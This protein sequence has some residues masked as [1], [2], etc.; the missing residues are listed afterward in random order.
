M[1]LP[2]LNHLPFDPGKSC[3]RGDRQTLIGLFHLRA[4][5]KVREVPYLL[6]QYRA[7]LYSTKPLSTG[8]R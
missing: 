7:R 1:R 4:E 8:S 2:I 5:H 3:E 6:C